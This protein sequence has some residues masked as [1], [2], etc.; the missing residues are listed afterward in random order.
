MSSTSTAMSALEPLWIMASGEAGSGAA[1]DRL[2][3]GDDPIALRES[4]L[5][6]VRELGRHRVDRL[7]SQLPAIV[8]AHVEE[9]V[10]PRAARGER[11]VELG[12]GLLAAEDDDGMARAGL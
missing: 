6:G 12:S 2:G 7:G 3:I 4:A 8:E 11:E 9:A 1:G 5:V 10:L